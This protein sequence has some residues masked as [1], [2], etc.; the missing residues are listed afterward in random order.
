[1][2]IRGLVGPQTPKPLSKCSKYDDEYNE[3]YLS[4]H[5]TG[6]VY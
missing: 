5:I 3:E 6:K 4:F 2:W 1:M